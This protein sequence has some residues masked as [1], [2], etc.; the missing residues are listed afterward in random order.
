MHH[1]YQ[2][3]FLPAREFW[4]R[5]FLFIGFLLAIPTFAGAQ[6]DLPTGRDLPA[7]KGSKGD[8][9][10]KPVGAH[11]RCTICKE[12]NQSTRMDPASSNGFQQA[13]CKVCQ[14]VTLHRQI[15]ARAGI[16]LDLPQRVNSGSGARDARDSDPAPTP[17]LPPTADRVL[18]TADSL[19]L[20]G[21]QRA[22]ADIL[23]QLD[24]VARIDDPVALQA[25]ETLLALGEPGLEAA[26]LALASEGSARCM[27]GLRVLL[28]GGTPLDAER[29]LRR[30]RTRMPGRLGGAALEEFIAKDPVH[31]T[32]K[33][34]CEMLEHPQNPVRTAAF[35]A[36]ADS[37]TPVPLSALKPVLVSRNGDSRS[38]A[39][40]LLSDVPGPEAV[41]LLIDGIDDA[42]PRVARQAMRALATREDPGITNSLLALAFGDRWILRTGACALLAIVDRED[43]RLES[44]LGDGHVE[45]LLRGLSSSD[46]FVAGS[47]ATALAGVG[48]RSHRPETSEWLEHAVPA[49]LVRVVS[50]FR[51]FDD[52]EA[53]SAPALRRLK[54]V[55]GVSHGS[56]GPAWANWWMAQEGDF[57]A[58]RAVIPVSE[59]SHRW[60][61]IVI[62]ERASGQAFTLLGP[63]LAPEPLSARDGEAFYLSAGQ[64]RDLLDL[65]TAEQLLSATRL[66]GVR[67]GQGDAARRLELRLA[68]RSKTFVLGPGIQ[69]DWFDHALG[70]AQSLRIRNL[71]QRH[72]HPETHGTRLG[73]WRAEG[74]WWELDHS[75][76]ERRARWGELI[77]ARLSALSAAQR[78]DDLI[79]LEELYSR[80]AG[81]LPR[82]FGDLVHMLSE[83]VYFTGR[84]LRIV[85]LAQQSLGGGTDPAQRAADTDTL[86]GVLHDQFGM[87]AIGAITDVL[88]AAPHATAHAAAADSRAL[89]RAVAAFVLADRL[90]TGDE[91]LV[92]GL[93]EDEAIPVR[94]AAI[95]ACGGRSLGSA[96]TQVFLAASAG[97]P[98]VRVPAL[99]AAGQI[100]GEGALELLVT[101]LTGGDRRLHLAAAK[102]LAA[103]EDPDAIPIMLSILRHGE[104]TDALPVLRT[105]L[106][107][108]GDQAWDSLFAALRSPSPALRRDAA[109]IL[110]RQT[111]AEAA[112]ALIRVL[113]EDPLDDA[114][115]RELCVLTCVDERGGADPA[116]AWFRWWDNVVHDDPLA[117]LRAAGEARRIVAPEAAEFAGRG[118]RR[119]H[120]F[121]VELMAQDSDWL[122]ERAR[123]GL[124]AM[125][126]MEIGAPP[127]LGE[128]RD[129][130]LSELMAT[131]G[132]ER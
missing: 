45:A 112:P 101:A 75:D 132:A 127:P 98:D 100:G 114:V 79:A 56:D 113:A 97:D 82:D 117:W 129:A 105:G 29:V 12:T 31:A 38:K 104:R 21:L 115:A 34:L 88:S 77:V 68:G 62:E 92:L 76:E 108:L 26:R 33:L 8:R 80:G 86:M 49:R 19:N 27:T 131:L 111:V 109:M 125:T 4:V 9:S 59:D 89:M 63:K 30:L 78:G 1:A 99:F 54:Q 53:L 87:D 90:G 42:R 36:L 41:D 83:E 93:I 48:F 3:T 2:I 11:L 32:P 110:A 40:D 6:I 15:D 44:I 23:V 10:G 55:A 13:D 95:S 61:Q 107:N 128:V 81:G 35:R 43:A 17:G 67:G 71:W 46:E 106:L 66:P 50:G 120:A 39:M 96:R 47:C 37:A 102:G 116:E 16:G 69:E 64:A 57:R 119:A 118:T 94:V 25:V 24:Q 122:V 74:A 18:P 14:K 103:L 84:A 73:L 126:G 91:A 58:C 7:M 130:W 52:Y 65:L 51:Y 124:E 60:L 123:R 5:P 28:R 85:S 121:L 22:A 20:T 72:P 70:F